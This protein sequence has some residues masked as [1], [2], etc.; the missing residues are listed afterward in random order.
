MK[1]YLQ[2]RNEQRET[3]PEP[4]THKDDVRGSRDVVRAFLAEYTGV[5]DFVFDPFAG[6]GTTLFVAEEMGRRV[7]G[8]EYVPERCTYIRERLRSPEALIQGDA[9][10][11]ASYNLPRIDF[12]L[13]SPPYMHRDDPEDPFTAYQAPGRSYD[14]YLADIREIYRQIG[15]LM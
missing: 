9:R 7:R 6:F 5:G 8:I 1:T 15:Q 13:T 4:F 12:S 10:Q 11:L 3:L 14:A 2:V